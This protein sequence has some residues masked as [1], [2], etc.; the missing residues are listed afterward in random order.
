M[1]VKVEWAIGDNDEAIGDWRNARFLPLHGAII[2]LQVATPG[3]VP[4]LVEVKKDVNA[5]PLDSAN[6]MGH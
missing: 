5:T 2:Q 6:A 4:M 3:A 1:S